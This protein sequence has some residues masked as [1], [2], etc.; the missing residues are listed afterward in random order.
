MPKAG[1]IVQGWTD[2]PALQKQRASNLLHLS[3][4]SG[5]SLSLHDVPRLQPQFPFKFCQ[6]S[7][8]PA[9]PDGELA[10]IRPNRRRGPGQPVLLKFLQSADESIAGILMAVSNC[11]AF[12]EQANGANPHLGLM[13]CKS[14]LQGDMPGC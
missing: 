9:C 2:L 13:I 7:R 11:K 14:L 1:L 4:R 10:Q 8:L 5:M 3:Q 6:P 12:L